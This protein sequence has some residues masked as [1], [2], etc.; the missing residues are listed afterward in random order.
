[1]HALSK[2]EQ[3]TVITAVTV[4]TTLEW[5]EI[6]LY[7]YWAP[8][9]SKLFFP[10]NPY[11]ENLTDVFLIFGLGFL[12]RPLGGIFFGRIGDLIG[13]KKSLILSIVAMTFPTFIMGLLPTY[14]QIGILAPILLAIMRLMQAFP[15]AGETPGAACFLYESGSTHNRRFIS[16]WAAVGNQIGVILSMLECYFL[17]HLLDPESII[18]WGWRFS[19]MVGGLIGLFGLYL[20]HKLHET[21][22][23]KSL[24]SHHQITKSKT[25]EVLFSNR[26]KITKS[27]LFCAL[28]ASAFYLLS[29]LFPVYFG[30][31]LGSNYSTNLIIGILIIALST[32]PLPLFGAL[33]DKFSNKKMLIFS[34]L[35]IALITLPLY[36]SIINN[37]ISY[38]LFFSILFI[39][40]TSCITALLPY[41]LCSLFETPFRFTCF[42]FGFNIADGIIGGFSP[43]IALFLLNLTGNK[44]SF[45]WI[46]LTCALISLCSFFTI[47]EKKQS[48]S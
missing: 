39:I 15:A 12:A 38:M 28:D 23:F 36:T 21:P 10:K 44:V 13:R 1:M 47:N 34:S 42:G 18:S 19:F 48:L 27:I 30:E 14:Q 25:T 4:G 20:R 41:A 8:I 5:Y 26:N 37:Q 35:G 46:I 45:V 11:V 24:K 43:A 31:A 17:E 3:W 7:V 33:G 16:S 22:V 6:Y 2:K 32:L 29:V 40:L 9:I